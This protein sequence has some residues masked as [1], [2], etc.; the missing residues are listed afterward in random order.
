MGCFIVFC[1]SLWKAHFSEYHKQVLIWGPCK[2]HIIVSK[3]QVCTITF[4]LW[5][6]KVFL[7]RLVP[8]AFFQLLKDPWEQGWWFMSLLSLMNTILVCV[9][10][11]S[12]IGKENLHLTSDLITVLSNIH[13]WYS[14]IHSCPPNSPFLVACRRHSLFTRISPCSDYCTVPALKAWGF[15]SRNNARLHSNYHLQVFT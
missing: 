6:L 12:G 2:Q 5:Y 14:P 11:S 8:L 10:V 9:L 13:H 15:K 4:G 7:Y 1:F 3:L